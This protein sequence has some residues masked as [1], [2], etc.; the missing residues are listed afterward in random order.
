M[1]RYRDL[2]LNF[3]VKEEYREVFS[4]VIIKGNSYSNTDGVLNDFIQTMKDCNSSF[5]RMLHIDYNQET[6]EC[7]LKIEYN[8]HNIEFHSLVRE[9]TEISLPNVADEIVYLYDYLEDE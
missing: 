4:S 5:S 1:S 3:V 7:S 6:G 9:F 2:A 8:V